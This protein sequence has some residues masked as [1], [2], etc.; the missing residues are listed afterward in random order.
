MSLHC[1]QQEFM[2][3]HAV[4][5]FFHP[6]Q[7]Y[8]TP[9][10]RAQI[11]YV[12]VSALVAL[13]IFQSVKQYREAKYVNQVAQQVT[14]RAGSKDTLGTVVALRDYLRQNVT[15][16]GFPAFGRPVLRNTAAETL[17][18]GKGRCGESTRAFINMAGSLGIRARRLYL[19]GRRSHVVALVTLDNEQQVIVDSSDRPYFPDLE[20][21]AN[22]LGHAEF[23]YYTSFNPHR[24]VFGFGKNT[25]NFG[26][27]NYFFENPNAFLALFSFALA[28]SCVGIR[29]LRHP[30]RNWRKGRANTARGAKEWRTASAS[31]A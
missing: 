15:R 19:E 29:W 31:S 27:L 30:L 16:K 23:D 17:A 3:L 5:N 20:P 12:A 13:G 18:S 10:R 1:G 8:L 26:P 21:L 11:F 6:I 4:R 7:K 25:V 24:I 2:D 9:R 22:V 14:T 28:F